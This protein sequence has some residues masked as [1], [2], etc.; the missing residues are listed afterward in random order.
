MNFK[1]LYNTCNIDLNSGIEIK[2]ASNLKFY[3]YFG[4]K[5]MN[6]LFILTVLE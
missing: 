4:T 3:I 5:Q 6:A 2:D 1:N